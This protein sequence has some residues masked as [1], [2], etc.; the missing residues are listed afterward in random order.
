MNGMLVYNSRSELE[1]ISSYKQSYEGDLPAGWEN[2][3][4]RLEA[5]LFTDQRYVDQRLILQQS[6]ECRQQMALM[7]VPTET[8][9]GWTHFTSLKHSINSFIYRNTFSRLSLIYL[10]YHL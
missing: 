4:V 3:F 6:V 7:V 8:V 2:H 5:G 10:S 9:V 1:S